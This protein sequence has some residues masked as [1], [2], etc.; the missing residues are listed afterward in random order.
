MIHLICYAWSHHINIFIPNIE[1]HSTPF[2]HAVIWRPRVVYGEITYLCEIG[3]WRN[4]GRGACGVFHN[5][6]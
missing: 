5:D 2:I 1:M 4:T 6:T 3:Q